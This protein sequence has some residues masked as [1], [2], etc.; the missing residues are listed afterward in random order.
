MKGAWLIDALIEARAE[1]HGDKPRGCVRTKSGYSRGCLIA[2]CLYAELDTVSYE[3][4]SYRHSCKGV[5]HGIHLESNYQRRVG[6]LEETTA[7]E[8]LHISDWTRDGMVSY[9]VVLRRSVE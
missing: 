7:C 9:E 3:L 6:S 4:I 5:A 8:H 2:G 1:V